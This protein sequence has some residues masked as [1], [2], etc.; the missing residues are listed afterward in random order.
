MELIPGMGLDW[1]EG[2]GFGFGFGSR[3]GL[4]LVDGRGGDAV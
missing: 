4:G 3:D 2:F 1:R